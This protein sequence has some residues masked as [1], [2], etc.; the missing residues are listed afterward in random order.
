MIGV[1]ALAYTIAHIIIY[2]ALRFWDFASI[3]HEM[4]TRISLILAIVGTIGLIAL[5]AI[6]VDAAVR[7]TGAKVGSGCTMRST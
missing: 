3:A 5:G 4:V 1:T 6:S 2:F 7:R